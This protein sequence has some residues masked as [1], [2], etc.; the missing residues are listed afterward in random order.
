MTVVTLGQMPDSTVSNG[1]VLME[2]DNSASP[3]LNTDISVEVTCNGGTNWTPASLSSVGRGQA[4]R[5]VVETVDQATTGGTDCRAR[6]KK[7]TNK[8]IPIY[9]LS[10]TWN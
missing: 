2:I 5:L 3:T 10:L 8:L 6:V 1:R 4:G 9:G 7:L